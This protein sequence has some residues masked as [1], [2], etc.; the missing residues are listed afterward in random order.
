MKTLIL[1]SSKYGCTKKYVSLLSKE[2][3]G[4]IKCISLKEKENP[5]LPSTEVVILGSSVYMG[6]IQKEMKEFCMHHLEELKAKKLHLFITCMNLSKGQEQLENAYPKELLERAISKEVLGG[7]LTPTKMNFFE[8]SII[9]AVTKQ[10]PNLPRIEG[11]E[12]ISLL[13]EK[14]LLHFATTIQKSMEKGV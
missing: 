14:K 8:K 2:L 1:Y 10:D 11:Q 6:K 9:K 4:E 13:D 12:G 5:S 7:E 3:Q